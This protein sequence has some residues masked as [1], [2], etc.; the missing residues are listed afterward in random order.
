MAWAKVGTVGVGVVVVTFLVVLTFLVVVVLTLGATANK[1][2]EKLFSLQ[3]IITQ[4]KKFAT[5]FGGKNT[6][7]TSD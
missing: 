7:P 3:A 4:I 6:S 5:R 1:N 2:Y